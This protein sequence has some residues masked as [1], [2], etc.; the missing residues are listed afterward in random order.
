MDGNA[1]HAHTAQLQGLHALGS[2]AL[3]PHAHAAQLQGP[4][5][6]GSQTQGSCAQ[7]SLVS[8]HACLPPLP[9][10]LAARLAEHMRRKQ[11]KLQQ[12]R[13]PT[14]SAARVYVH[15]PVYLFL[16]L[17]ASMGSK[18]QTAEGWQGQV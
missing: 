11:R 14:G 9:P 6:L 1:V 18:T 5:A 3:G 16:C 10:L 4:H 13:R 17:R 12:V 7:G 2:Q 8:S 15:L